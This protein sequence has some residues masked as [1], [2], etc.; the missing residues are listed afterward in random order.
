MPEFERQGVQ[1]AVE[2]TLAAASHLD[3]E[4]DAALVAVLRT[5]ARRVDELTVTGW[6]AD[7][8]LDNV[9]VPTFLKTCAALRLDPAA[10]IPR[11]GDGVASSE[12][13]TPI[14]RPARPARRR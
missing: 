5:L 1:A 12:N 3:P 4:R 7:G 14:K 13:V 2:R 10:P 9:T 8:K 6:E 11:A